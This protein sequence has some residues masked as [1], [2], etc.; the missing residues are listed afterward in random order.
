ML[1]ATNLKIM[2]IAMLLVFGVWFY[3][4]WKYNKYENKRQVENA[5]QLERQDSI[6]S[7]YVVYS[8]DQIKKYVN[9]TSDLKELTKQNN[10]DINRIE[11]IMIAKLQY[12]DTTK[13][14]VDLAPVLAAINTR[15]DFELPVIDSTQCLIIKGTVKYIND[16]LSFTF[17]DKRYKDKI[18]AVAYWERRQW[19]LFWF[20]TRIFGKRQDTAIIKSECGISQLIQIEK[21]KND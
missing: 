19:K 6:H 11:K 8:Q 7:A 5:R 17:E 14:K 10:I 1:T 3:Q 13:R 20:R 21:K 2:F 4:D 18:T 9:N 16:K 12:R 15:S